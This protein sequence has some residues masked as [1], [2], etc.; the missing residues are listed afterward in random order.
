MRRFEPVE[1]S[2]DLPRLEERVLARWRERDVF[3]ESLRRRA[4]AP[5]FVFYEGPP[6]ANG[7]PGSHHVLSR[8]FKDVFPRYKTMRG[9]LVERKAGWDCHGLPVELEI[10][11]EL[12]LNSK[13]EI[14]RFGIAEFNRR[15]RE[16][17]FKYIEDWNRLTERIGFWIDLDDAYATLTN[18]YIESVW[19]S[20][21]Q[22]WE[23]GLLYEGHKVVPYCPRCGTAL[24]SHEVALG[25]RDV[26]DPSVYVRFPLRDE[27]GVALLAWTTTPWTL[28]SN[29]ALAVNPQVEYARVG[30]R[31]E[32]LI[33]ARELVE[34]VLG[35]EARVVAT[36]AGAELV[37]RRYEP[38]FEYIADWGPKGHTVL[39]ADFVTTDE[40]T[41]VVHTAV[42]FGED[43]F[44]LG[45]EHGLPVHNP[46]RED[47]TFDER[48]GPFAGKFVKDAD[49]EIVAA[50]R[51]RGRLLRAEEIVHSYPHCWRCDTPLLYYAKT[52]W[53][54][55]TT[56]VR[57]RMLAENEKVRWYP[58]HIKHGRFG[59]WL[60]NNIDW[61]LSRERYWGTPL[62][63]WRCREG[64]LHC[65]GSVAELRDLAGDVP[66]DLHKP[67]IDEVVFR[68]RECGGEMR[69]VPEVIDAWWDS[70]AMPFA[71]WH[72]PFENRDRFDE[73]FPA[74]YISEAI[75]QTR[76]WFYSLLAVS[77]LLF[78]RSP[79]RTVV[80]LGLILDEHGQKMSKSR[81]NVVD[82]WAVIERFGADAFRWYYFTAKQPWDGYRFSLETVGEATR[83]FLRTLWS[84]YHFF[85]LYANLTDSPLPP[86][87]EAELTPLDRW[88]L[89]RLAGLCARVVERM[90]DYDTTSA[91]R[92]IAEYVDE[93]SNWYV[94]LSRR[95]FWDG[96]GAALATL[97][98]CLVVL[99]KLL[100]PF[101]PFL[102]D[103]IYSNLDGSEPS[104][105]LCAFPEP[106]E[107]DA[108]LEWQMQVVR[109]AVELG[110]AARAQ[111]GVKLRQPLREA[112]VVA[113]G[114]ER[115]AIAAFE[116]LVREELNVKAVRYV[117]AAEEL[118]RVQ[119]KP[120]WRRLGPRFG[121]RM[122][123]LAQALG[124]ID[125]AAA[126]RE[127]R[128]GHAI[129][130]EVEG[131]RVELAA[132]DVQ[133]VLE[134]LEGYQVERAGT[135]AV[136]LDLEIDEAL[137]REGLARELVHAIQNA[138]KEAGLRV[139][140]RIRLALAG[141]PE[142]L[143]VAR[144]FEQEIAR[145]TLAR[146]VTYGTAD[147]VVMRVEG[148]ELRIAVERL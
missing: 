100:A 107:R 53:Y 49:P 117:E 87:A 116:E 131:E 10:E 71:Q 59:N 6:T 114:R 51:E 142:L 16:S 80:C 94:R 77:T 50:L 99:S 1:P 17:V 13:H 84:T 43:D 12:G 15:C 144:A 72:Y 108:E 7:R 138:R 52:S 69:R 37:G 136:A 5:R 2:I 98:H 88:A 19:W 125:A 68:C 54:V 36:M 11:R 20:L 76:G 22:V 92:A 134:P 115:D 79:Y 40:G 111:A 85:V 143:E 14:E 32:E 93:L 128:A 64:H 81:G 129:A 141:D 26:S 58:E 122:P 119:L 90:D 120:N 106:G 104:V 42:A 29:A 57:E 103:A 30:Y 139:E 121:K 34:R 45:Q 135:H 21:R 112:V 23:K 96:D 55:R 28:L 130:V 146:E 44:R 46:V 137:R 113:P 24:S 133:V 95:R 33:L 74:D 67:Y 25:Y 61:A 39:A 75:D 60:A 4:G 127:L 35:E 48:V 132:D 126:A 73:N 78:D 145:E 47:G 147:G 62:P 91:G 109:D 9:F 63:I 66:D 86:L 38:P 65:V 124:A 83:P 31:G 56:A 70:G 82:P 89:S 97:H 3:R 110:R 8:V 41:G 102:A 27:R 18:D 148:R 105:H 140:D 118:G 101:T 123:K